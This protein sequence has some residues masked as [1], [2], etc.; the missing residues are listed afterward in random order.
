MLPQINYNSKCNIKVSPSGI[1]GN[2][3]SVQKKREKK[4]HICTKASKLSSMEYSFSFFFFNFDKSCDIL[5]RKRRR[6]L[7]SF[8]DN[9]LSKV[10]YLFDSSFFPIF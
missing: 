10:N 6:N 5:F 3:G 7:D 1:T 8:K 2:E 4:M 9:Y